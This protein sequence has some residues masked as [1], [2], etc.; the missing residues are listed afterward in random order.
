MIEP[1]P[2]L[3]DVVLRV[4][5]PAEGADQRQ[6]GEQQAQHGLECPGP[7]L[8]AERGGEVAH[9]VIVALSEG[10]H[11]H[12]EDQGHAGDRGHQ[13]GGPETREPPGKRQTDRRAEE[14]E[15]DA[16][17]GDRLPQGHRHS[18]SFRALSAISSIFRV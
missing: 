15:K 3:R 17:E 12:K 9:G 16:R 18:R 7:Q 14:R 5:A 2:P 13:K 4:T 11:V 8:V 1:L 10:D 6:A